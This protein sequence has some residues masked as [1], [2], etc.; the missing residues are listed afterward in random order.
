MTVYIDTSALYAVLDASDEHHEAA[1]SRWIRLLEHGEELVCNNN[2]SLRL[3]PWSSIVW[4]WRLY[5]R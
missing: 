3:M 4:G 5:A 2:E 1:K